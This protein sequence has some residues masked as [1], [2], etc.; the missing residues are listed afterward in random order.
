MSNNFWYD[1][2]HAQAMYDSREPPEPHIIGHCV[3]C[4]KN[5]YQCEQDETHYLDNGNLSHWECFEVYI[6]GLPEDIVMDCL[7]DDEE[8][9]YEE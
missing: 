5:I 9:E 3:F 8:Y 6:E 7:P 4:E 1:F 2:D